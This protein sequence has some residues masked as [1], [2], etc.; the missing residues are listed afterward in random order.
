MKRYDMKSIY[1]HIACEDQVV[2]V[3]CDD[4]KYVKF[5]DC[6]QLQERI[7]LLESMLAA[8]IYVEERADKK[9]TELQT[10]IVSVAELHQR[11][12]ELEL[13]LLTAEQNASDQ[14][15]MK[16]LAREQRDEQVK[17]NKELLLQVDLLLKDAQRYQWIRKNIE[18][19]VT[20][21]ADE[22]VGVKTK[23]KLPY[24]HAYAEFTGQL[25][26]DES[27][28]SQIGGVLNE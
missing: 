11:N 27:I 2:E 1:N 18:E 15:A 3:E 16:S 5:S 24:L 17:K 22:F 23:F 13:L 20:Q 12:L 26:L 8:K 14:R 19:E 25:T 7:S 9:I 4:G 6:E 28:D 10:K 21:R